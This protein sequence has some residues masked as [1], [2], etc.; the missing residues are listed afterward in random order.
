ML[1]IAVCDD[2]PI[3]CGTLIHVMEKLLYTRE[4]ELEDFSNGD[5]LLSAI[6]KDYNFYHL[7]FLDIDMPKL[8]GLETAAILREIPTC[9][10]SIIVFITNYDADISAITEIHPFAYIKKDL[11]E[12]ELI[13]KLKYC[14]N[15]FPEMTSVYEVK[16]YGTYT[17][18]VLESVLYIESIKRHTNFYLEDNS[19]IE[20]TQMFKKVSPVI[21][22]M[23]EHFV[24]CHKSI[25][26]NMKYIC[27]FERSYIV[28][29][30]QKK[31]PYN[32]SYKSVILEKYGMFLLHTKYD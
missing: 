7:F 21:R 28:L 8:N 20:S 24:Q 27:S 22:Q 32:Y 2:D 18:I 5:E 12:T 11:N 19:V 6:E 29:K 3:F 30:N 26:V 23:D 17:P 16:Y 15:Q 31:I 1:K 10:N 14:L 25:L 13:A 4:Y 9:R